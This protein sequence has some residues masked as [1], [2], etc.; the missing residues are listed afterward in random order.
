MQKMYLSGSPKQGR[1]I[2]TALAAG[3]PELGLRK[4]AFTSR[5]EAWH[6]SEAVGER[7]ES[8]KTK[9]FW[10]CEPVHLIPHTSTATS[11]RLS[12]MHTATIWS[13]IPGVRMPMGIP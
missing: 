9:L 10:P 5:M 1:G 7:K 13:L 6:Y 12:S 8:L 2:F 4:I 3:Q 11:F